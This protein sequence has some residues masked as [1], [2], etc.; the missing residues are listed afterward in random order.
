MWCGCRHWFKYLL[1]KF[2]L[3]VR[4]HQKVLQ[5]KNLREHSLI[6]SNVI[7]LQIISDY[8]FFFFLARNSVLYVKIYTKKKIYSKSCSFTLSTDILFRH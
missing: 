4:D 1:H 6:C 5:Q 8:S 7:N 3:A 2:N